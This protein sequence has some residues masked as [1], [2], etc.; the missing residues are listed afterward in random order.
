MLDEEKKSPPPLIQRRSLFQEEIP[1]KT[2][3]ED[4]EPITTESS[5]KMLGSKFHPENV[6]VPAD[7]LNKWE[8]VSSKTEPVE[9]NYSPLTLKEDPEDPIFEY[10][11]E[12]QGLSPLSLAQWPSV[13]NNRN[14]DKVIKDHFEKSDSKNDD[15]IILGVIG[16]GT[17]LSNTISRTTGPLNCIDYPES[18]DYIFWEPSMDTSSIPVSEHNIPTILE[19]KESVEKNDS[20]L[21]LG[22]VKKEPL[23]KDGSRTTDPLKLVDYSESDFS[24]DAFHIIGKELMDTSRIPAPEHEVS[25]ILK[26]NRSVSF[27]SMVASSDDLKKIHDIADVVKITDIEDDRGKAKNLS[28]TPSR[29]LQISK[30]TVP[31]LEDE[32][33]GMR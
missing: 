3:K 4:I 2:R 33:V 11:Y 16:T 5:E 27:S 9:I 26:Q 10:E 30:E 25:T 29:S 17:G 8:M 20:E 31:M 22:T 19:Q 21:M 32:F 23:N 15:M 12:K 13:L 14:N 6:P 28:I 7:P 1:K 18:E 24:R